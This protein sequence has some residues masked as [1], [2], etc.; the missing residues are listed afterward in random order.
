MDKTSWALLVALVGTVGVV[1]AFP[2]D[3]K[4]DHNAYAKCVQLHPDRYCRIVSG[5]PVEPLD[6]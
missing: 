2:V 6:K 1:L 3:R 5:F 4:P